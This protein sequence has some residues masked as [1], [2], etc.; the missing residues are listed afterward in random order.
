MSFLL[1]DAM[2]DYLTGA[3]AALP[4]LT[5]AVRGREAVLRPPRVLI[6]ELPPRSKDEEPAADEGGYPFVLL[7]VSAGEDREE[8]SACEVTLTCAVAAA[9]R[10]EAL[11][12]EIQNVVGWV[13]TALLKKRVLGGKCRLIP[14]NQ[15]RLLTWAVYP[16]YAYPYVA[17]WIKGTWEL[18]GIQITEESYD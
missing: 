16:E 7:R 8:L 13:R 1:L 5:P 4:L 14:D 17:A 18:P 11:E 2:R 15:D 6:G 3:L 10:G 12:H 9:E